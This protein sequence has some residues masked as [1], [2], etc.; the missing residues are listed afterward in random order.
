MPAPRR[1]GVHEP[2]DDSRQ[3][4]A[5]LAALG[6]P[7]AVIGKRLGISARTL[8]RHYGDEV[9]EGFDRLHAELAQT[10]VGMA[11]SGDRTMLIFVLKTKFR[12]SE[13][14]PEDPGAGADAIGRDSDPEVLDR[15]EG[16]A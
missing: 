12:W 4:V 11:R 16:A 5:E 6:F 8:M 3:M 7:Q 15:G 2:T 10:A 9:R 1:E 13:Q 14:R